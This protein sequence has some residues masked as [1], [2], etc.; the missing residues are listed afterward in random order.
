MNYVVYSVSYY[1][2]KLPKRQRKNVITLSRTGA[3]Q[4]VKGV[5]SGGFS[6]T[7]TVKKSLAGKNATTL[8]QSQKPQNMGFTEIQAVRLQKS[9]VKTIGI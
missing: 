7:Y 5:K 8:S 3:Q 4:L 1:T 9:R 6:H 2:H